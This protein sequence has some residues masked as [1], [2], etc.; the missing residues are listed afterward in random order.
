M[1]KQ[2]RVS[3][4][5]AGAILALISGILYCV[6]IV[7]AVI[8]IFNILAYNR[9]KEIYTKPV[10]EA[11]QDLD[12]SIYFGWSIYLLIVMFPLGLL[13]FLPYVMGSQQNNS[14]NNSNINQE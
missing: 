11:N 4:V 12:N 14:N 13:S 2:T 8:G 7:G 1:S 5:K 3:L 10:D 9:L 6:T